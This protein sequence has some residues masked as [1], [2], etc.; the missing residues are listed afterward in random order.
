MQDVLA[1]MRLQVSH[2]G[3][4]WKAFGHSALENVSYAKRLSGCHLT[5][6]EGSLNA[7]LIMGSSLRFK[8]L[9][10]VSLKK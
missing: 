5:L 7:L 1:T 3:L 4:L 10:L 9:K 8:N 2:L 6:S